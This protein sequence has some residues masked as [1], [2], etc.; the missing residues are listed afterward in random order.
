MASLLGYVVVAKERIFQASRD[1][2][3]D[4]RDM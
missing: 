2:Q 3:E 1:L 4:N